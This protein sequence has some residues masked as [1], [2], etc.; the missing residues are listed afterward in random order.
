MSFDYFK[1]PEKRL[2][3]GRYLGFFIINQYLFF[4]F[5]PE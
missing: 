2:N 1:Y 4:I 3:N 5:Q